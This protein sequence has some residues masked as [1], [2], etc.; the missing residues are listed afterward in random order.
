MKTNKITRNKNYLFYVPIR[1][2]LKYFF[3]NYENIYFLILSVFQ[4]LTL[5]IIPSHWSPTGPYSTFIPL[6][7][8][9]F[10]EI[11]IDFYKWFENLILDYNDNYRQFECYD[12]TFKYNKDI[13]KDDIIIL[14]YNDI[15]PIDGLLYDNDCNPE[16]IKISLSLLTGESNYHYIYKCPSK[17]IQNKTIIYSGSIIKSKQAYLYVIACGDDKKNHHDTIE[18]DRF[19]QLI[20]LFLIIC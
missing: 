13:K 19:L 14:K 18:S 4:L 7:F 6:M 15:V 10:I 16:Y 8:C 1:T 12:N 11:I 9:I 5:T 2:M 17:N 3:W 20:N